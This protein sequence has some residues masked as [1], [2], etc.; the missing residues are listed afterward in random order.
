[1]PRNAAPHLRRAGRLRRRL[2]LSARMGPALPGRY[3]RPWPRPGIRPE[4][5][6]HVNAHGLA[7]V[8]SDIWEAR[9]LHEV[10]GHTLPAVPVFAAKSYLGNLGAG[11]GIT[12]LALSILGLHHGQLPPTLEL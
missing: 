1:M 3:G 2:R 9:G 11:A 6:D 12:E 8:K 7:T 5:L 4:D 10:F